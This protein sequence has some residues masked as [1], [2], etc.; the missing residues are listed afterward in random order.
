[1]KE[2]LTVRILVQHLQ[3]RRAALE[4]ELRE[5]EARMHEIKGAIEE[6]RT[7]EAQANNGMIAQSRIG[8]E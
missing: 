3:G 7:L 6:T 8:C 5:I 4:T 2:Q 1:M